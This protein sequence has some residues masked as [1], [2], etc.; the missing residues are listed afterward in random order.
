MTYFRRHGAQITYIILSIVGVAISIYLTIAHYGNVPVVC[1][2]SG[3]INCERVL[4]SSYS[5]VPGTSIP[6]SVPGLLWFLVSG[7]L[8]FTAW[9]I[10]PEARSL[11]IAEPIWFGTG[12]LTALYLVYAE[13]V[14]LHNICAWCTVLHIIM[15]VMFLVAVFQLMQPHADDEEYY[16]EDDEGDEAVISQVSKRSY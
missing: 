1:S 11:K 2:T 13:L 8:A 15:L 5:L 7:A 16:E 14:Y 9:K 4:S 12:V 3:V 6:I 10:R